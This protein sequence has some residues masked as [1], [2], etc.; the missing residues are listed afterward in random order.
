MVVCLAGSVVVRLSIGIA[1]G[2]GI[3]IVRVSIGLGAI[4]V[5]VG[6]IRISVGVAIDV[7]ISLELVV[8]QIVSRRLGF[9]AVVICFIRVRIVFMADRVR[10]FTLFR[11]AAD[12]HGYRL[13]RLYHIAGAGQLKEDAISLDLIAGADSAHAEVQ[14]GAG[15]L[16]L[17]D[18]SILADDVRHSY[19]RTA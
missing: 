8:V 19:F 16:T 9:F 18:K 1:I 7:P 15:Q 12:V 6:G 13:T 11:R 10:R 3:A 2:A 17:S 4:G 14:A 5:W